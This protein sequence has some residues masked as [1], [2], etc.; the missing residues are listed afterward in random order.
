[1]T[2]AD[3]VTV[4]QTRTVANWLH[5]DITDFARK[6]ERAEQEENEKRKRDRKEKASES[7]DLK[8]IDSFFK[9]A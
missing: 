2:P 1:V 9:K 5:E 7:T 3:L 4:A 8:G 6:S